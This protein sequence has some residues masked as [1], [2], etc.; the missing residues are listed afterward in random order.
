M[1]SADGAVSGELHISRHSKFLPS[2]IPGLDD[3]TLLVSGKASGD[4]LTLTD[5]IKRPHRNE[6][7]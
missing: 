3:Y 2:V 7:W 6:A 1:H 4:V 5:K